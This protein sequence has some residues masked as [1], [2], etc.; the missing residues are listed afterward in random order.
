MNDKHEDVGGLIFA[1]VITFLTGAA[2]FITAC[3]L[4]HKGM[5]PYLVLAFT[6]VGASQLVASVEIGK[7]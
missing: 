1:G 7:F 5:N 6:A 3:I 2:M 4:A